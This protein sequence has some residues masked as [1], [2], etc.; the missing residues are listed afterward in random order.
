LRKFTILLTSIIFIILCYFTGISA[1]RVLESDLELP[2]AM[3]ESA[4]YRIVLITQDLDTPFWDQVT[5]A[6]QRQAEELG[7]S[8]E[9]WGNYG[10]HEEDFLRNLEIAIHSKVDGIIVQGLD[11]NAFKE[12]TKIKASFYGIPVITIA[13]DVPMNESLRRSYVG[14]DQYEAG[15]LIAEQLIH[16]MGSIGQVIL[17][18]DNNHEYFIKQRIQGIED[19]LKKYAN[20]DVFYGETPSAR[21]DVITSTQNILNEV[22]NADAFIAVSA[23]TVGAMVQEISKRYQID[24]FYIYSFDDSPE[25]I[26]LLRE[27]KLDGVIR[28]SP[29]EMGQL[30]VELMVKWL[31][32]EA[33]P[34]NTE[35][36]FTEI[37]ILKANDLR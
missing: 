30:S 10:G 24:P 19:T 23:N 12:L 22:P 21:E 37:K 27:G 33:V 16:D 7:V 28:Q 36:Y 20:I 35:G 32:G 15:K 34:L 11:T 4:A 14:S 25:S 29:V 26:S 17:M 6:A 1:I 2:E 13:N 9:T 3:G 18:Y 5:V 8:L 31:K